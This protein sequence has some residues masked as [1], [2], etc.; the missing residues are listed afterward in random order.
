MVYIGNSTNF[1]YKRAYQ[2]RKKLFRY[3]PSLKSSV[4]DAPLQRCTLCKWPSLGNYSPLII[5]P[6]DS[7]P[8]LHPL[9][10]YYLVPS[11]FWV[12]HQVSVHIRYYPALYLLIIG[13][14]LHHSSSIKETLVTQKKQIYYSI[15]IQT[16]D[17][18][19]V[20]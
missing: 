14:L 12:L 8:Y 13:T 2:A 18:Q 19:K 6:A 17:N 7:Q 11:L 4:P 9:L 15:T 3:L 10:F 16:K 5:V 1:I 20:K